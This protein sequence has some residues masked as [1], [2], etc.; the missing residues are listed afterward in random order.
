[1]EQRKKSSKNERK[2]KKT[3]K[4]PIAFIF[5]WAMLLQLAACA[6]APVPDTPDSS[7]SQTEESESTSAAEA[8][9]TEAEADALPAVGEELY[10]FTLQ[11]VEPYLPLNAELL[12]FTHE[13]SGAQLCY[14][15]N[16]DTNRSFSIAYR[17]PHVDETDANHVFEHAIL[18]S[19]DKYPSQD[20]FFDL[21][22]KTYNT[23]V[24]ASTHLTYTLF[25]VSSQSE[26]QL[27]RLADAYLS[28]MVS[29]SLLQDER[30]F[31]R[32]ALRYML[33][34]VEEPIAMGGTVFSE[35]MGS[36]TDIQGEAYRNL[37]QTLYPGEYSAN[38][39]GRAHIN[40]RDLTFA[41]MAETFERS[42]HFDNS[43][44]LLYGDL[45]YRNFLAF[46]DR[47]YL[48]KAEKHG[49]DLS[50]YHDPVT[51]P[52]Y[53]EAVAYA[54]AYEGDST[55][56]ASMIYYA[57]DLDGQDWETIAQLDLFA[58]MLDRDSSIFHEKVKE[59]GLTAPVFAGIML[60]A[61]KPIFC[62]GMLY[63]NPED[64][65]GFKTAVD[66]TLADVADK[67]LDGELVETVMKTKM[68]SDYTTLENK[69]LIIDALFP[70]LC[71]Q[72]AKTGDT[73]F[74]IKSEEAFLAM[75]Q[76]TQQTLI[77][78]LAALLKDIPHSAMSTTIPQPGLAE[79]M[80]AEQE[81]YLAEM[82]ASMTFKELEQMV[83]D[84]LAFDEWN[85]QEQ[86]NSDIVIPV[87]ELPDLEPAAEFT[88]EEAEGALYYSA[89]SEMEEI[90]LHRIYFDSSAVPQEDLHYITLYSLLVEEL[91]AGNYSKAQKDNLME[92]YLY[93][94]SMDT[95][96]P[97]TGENQYPMLFMHWYCMAEDYE[98]SLRLL[99]EIMEE[100]DFEDKEE[101]IRVLDKYL[102]L[103]DCARKDPFDLSM[104]MALAGID[105]STQYQD[106]LNGQ[107]FYTFARTLREKLDTD[108]NALEEIGEKLHSLQKQIL[109][110]DRMVVMHVAPQEDL[111]QILNVSKQV[112]GELPLLHPAE[113]DYQ[114]PKLPQKTAVIVEASNN[115]TFSA[116]DTALAENL[117]G[118]FFPFVMALSDRYIVPQLRFQALAYGAAM[119]HSYELKHIYTYTYS[120]PNVADTAA[121]IDGEA[122]AL[123]AMELTQEDLDG[124]ILSS[125]SYMTSPTGELNG[126]LQAMHR[127]LVGFDVQNWRRLGEEI[128]T[129]AV[130]DKEQAVEIL[131][132]LL[133]N[134]YLVTVGNAELI[135]AE[136]DSFDQVYDYRKPLEP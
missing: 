17:T 80:L 126:Y 86:S 40:Y 21:L 24:N 103:L 98:T 97:K 117:T 104:Q 1:M 76:D 60:D 89:A 92:Q 84:T 11:A 53:T 34:D 14:I 73:D 127:D 132:K 10:G 29:P 83:A 30:I 69:D 101:L 120:D 2:F 50:A 28:C 121:V 95:I 67:G 94:F 114:L 123:A 70:L 99:L 74:L 129:A 49:T 6:Q 55:E 20:L 19:S 65:A 46:I 44:I 81:A 125:Y 25:P 42:Y 115:Y 72:W 12:S 77:R 90:S 62:F 105:R 75:Q 130:E 37:Y 71:M 87:D 22:G 82:K 47:E 59:A 15:K 108:P 112:L 52:G 32:E 23:Y 27:L 96:Y 56:D 43:L 118:K 85:A 111:E 107:Q 136:A 134:Q 102:P 88:K 135:Q 48:G 128:K 68:L 8:A 79:E 110:K 54:P 36:M 57:M 119:A 7:I 109:H 61:E 13:Q 18:S 4:K 64:A 133:E 39:V 78:N 116:C 106:Y 131:R 91:A 38:F 66:D 100:L 35:D 16:E 124:Y 5:L 41:H 51:A 58:S 26:E 113:A 9:E 122:D 33:Y 63:A 31:Q 93:H 3:M 45:D